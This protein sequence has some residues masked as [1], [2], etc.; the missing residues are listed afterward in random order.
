MAEL[1]SNLAESTTVGAIN[2]TTDPVTF[3]LAT[4]TGTKFPAAAVGSTD[5]FHAVIDTGTDT[6]VLRCQ[7]AGD[8]I[9]ADR[10]QE[11]TLKV[12]HVLGVKFSHVLTASALAQI[13]AYP[14]S[15]ALGGKGYLLTKTATAITGLA[16][17]A[18]GTAVLADSTQA[19]GLRWGTVSGGGGS[20]AN[21][22]APAFTLY[23]DGTKYYARR[24]SDQT[25]PYTSVTPH[26]LHQ[27]FNAACNE[28]GTGT[29]YTGTGGLIVLSQPAGHVMTTL[30]PCVLQNQVTVFG[31]G[32]G[33]TVRAGASASWGGTLAS[34]TAVFDA[35]QKSRVRIEG[36]RIDCAGIAGTTGIVFEKGSGA[37]GGNSAHS[38]FLLNEVTGFDI[39]GL[40]IGLQNSS[41]AT[42]TAWIFGNQITNDVANGNNAI[43]VAFFVGDAHYGWG[44]NIKM[45][46]GNSICM[47]IQANS[48]HVLNGGH[49]VNN[50]SSSHPLI[51]V[52]GGN[53]CRIEGIYF[54]NLSHGPA[55]GLNLA[56]G[57][58]FSYPMGGQTNRVVI[59]DNWCHGTL[60]AD[61][62]A[63]MFQID[64]TNGDAY[65]ITIANNIADADNIQLGITA[66]SMASGDTT[67]GLTRRPNPPQSEP[68]PPATPFAMLIGTEYMTITNVAGTSPNYT[69]TATRGVSPGT[70]AASHGSGSAAYQLCRFASIVDITNGTQSD[71]QDALNLHGNEVMFAKKFITADNGYVDGGGS[72]GTFIGQNLNH[73][74]DSGGTGSNMRKG[75]A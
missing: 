13:P 68:A 26:S 2:N 23:F 5:Y 72:P 30:A 54:D 44:N 34:P 20:S 61:A 19:T 58:S 59:S 35:N 37:T 8:Q 62:A 49:M 12:A 29:T 21:W 18:D 17:G 1:F 53:P 64:V 45:G 22:Q 56:D 7:R 63:S 55:V 66:A 57:G 15:S 42:S 43:G 70:A 38:Y 75:P 16:P 51:S 60:A 36:V 74:E 47:V 71:V 6:E 25:V 52:H 65:G 69:L 73:I 33:L 50:G 46:G 3:T 27:V 28:L 67:F 4:G 48:V 10:A 39:C 9:T 40:Q 31:P 24:E 32:R 41:G 11:G 14:Q